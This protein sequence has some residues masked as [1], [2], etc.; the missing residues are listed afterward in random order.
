MSSNRYTQWK[1]ISNSPFQVW[2]EKQTLFFFKD[3]KWGLN[4]LRKWICL[5]EI[6]L[7]QSY[8]ILKR[9][10]KKTH[11]YWQKNPVCSLFGRD[12][13]KVKSLHRS[14]L[15]SAWLSTHE[16]QHKKPKPLLTSRE[17]PKTSSDKTIQNPEGANTHSSLYPWFSV[18]LIIVALH[19]RR[20]TQLFMPLLFYNQQHNHLVQEPNLLI[21][22][23]R[24]IF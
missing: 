18:C 9:E 3:R 8:K 16:K 13:G 4:L 22:N 24:W 11:R 12:R 7:D 19:F 5:W 20:V 15:S 1:S 21:Q 14:S 6:N 2:S 23:Q 10:E 17:I